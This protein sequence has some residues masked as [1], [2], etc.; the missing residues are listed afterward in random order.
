MEIDVR[1]LALVEVAAHGGGVRRVH[2][3][4][5]A[6][7]GLRQPVEHRAAPT[8]GVLDRFE[9]RAAVQAVVR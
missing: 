6:P 4:Q 9:R 2:Q 5:R 3:A 1:P 8:H 7:L